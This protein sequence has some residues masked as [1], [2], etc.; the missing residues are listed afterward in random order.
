MNAVLH[1]LIPLAPKISRV[2]DGYK[3]FPAE[4]CG[5][6]FRFGYHVTQVGVPASR[7]YHANDPDNDGV[8]HEVQI[9]RAHLVDR[10]EHVTDLQ[11]SSFDMDELQEYETEIEQALDEGQT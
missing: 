10:H 7:P 2:I 3:D 9:L 5:F 6:K 11:L 8:S 1:A 4:N